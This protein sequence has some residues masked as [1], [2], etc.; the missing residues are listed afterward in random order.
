[1]LEVG[2]LDVRLGDYQVLWSARLAA[3]EG[4][5]VA[6]LGPNGS[7]K[8]TLMN[9]VS[10]L[11]RPSAGTVRFRGRSL[12]GLP[13]HRIVA[14]GVSHVLERR[15]LFPYLTVR[16]NV[17]LGGYNAAA[18]AGRAEQLARVTRLFPIVA[19]R[20]DQL[21]RTLSGG[22]QQMVAI[23]RGLMA[24]PRLLMIDE[25]FLGLAPRV[26][27]ELS[28]AIRR[29]NAE[30]VTIVFIEQNVELALSLAHRGYVLESGRTVL[31]GTS[32]ELLRSPEVRR[33]FLGG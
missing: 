28:E 31:E 10:G 19:T 27:E 6:L 26:V 3:A 24:R 22:E 29:I 13:P 18:R 5:I 9:T 4:E 16:Q 30:G 17:W 20:A 25:P 21:A 8:S 32:G 11:L 1:M 7:G 2:E 14:E 33:I 12:A 23:A 15:R